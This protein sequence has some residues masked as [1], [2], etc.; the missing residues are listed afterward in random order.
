MNLTKFLIEDAP[1]LKKDVRN[2]Q[3]ISIVDAWKHSEFLCR[4]YVMN[5]LTY[6]LY[7]VY[8]NKKTSKELWESLDQKYKTEDVEAKKFVMGRFLNYKMVD[9]KTVVGQVQELH[10]IFHEINVEGMM[11]SEA[12]QVATIIEKLPQ[13]WKDFKN[14]LKHRR[15]E[16]SI[17]DLII[18]LHIEECNKESKKKVE[19]PT[20]LRLTLWNMVKV[21]SSRKS[22]IKGKTPSWD[23]KGESLRS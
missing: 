13:A 19:I 10:V 23:L 6:S 9:F 12:F 18:R 7:N 16:M 5:A 22:T 11:L 15:K 17:E 20:R 8:S 3:V 21:P 14:Y 4:N 1:K 2:I